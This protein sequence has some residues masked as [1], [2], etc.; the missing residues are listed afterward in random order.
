MSLLTQLLFL[1][2]AVAGDTL[3]PLPPFECPVE[4]AVFI[5]YF[6][7]AI[8]PGCEDLP[9]ETAQWQCTQ[10]MINV[11]VRENF[12]W[13]GPLWCGEGMAVIQITVDKEGKLSNMRIVRSL[14]AAADKSCDIIMKAL[15]HNLPDEW[16]PGKMHD[17]PVD[18][19]YNWPVRFKL[20]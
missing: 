11:I 16:I 15:Q 17:Q 6:P 18:V 5:D 10:N 2:C 19:I 13:P 8:A 9:S 1:T 4:E 7:R 20:E 12:R 3:P 14:G